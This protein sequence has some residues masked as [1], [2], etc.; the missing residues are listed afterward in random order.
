MENDTKQCPWCY[1]PA[2][3]GVWTPRHGWQICEN[4]VITTY[5]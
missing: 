3:H 2:E 5:T 4:L 1:E